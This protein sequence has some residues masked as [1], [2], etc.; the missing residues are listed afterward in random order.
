MALV[1]PLLVMILLGTATSAIA[2]SQNSSITNATR[3]ASRFGA[4]KTVDGNLSTWL[5]ELA[6]VA[7]RASIG[8]VNVTKSGH[9]ICVAFVHPAGTTIEDTTRSLT[10]NSLGPLEAFTP[11]YADLRPNTER[12][13][14]VVIRRPAT[15]ETGFWSYTASLEA[16]S[17]SMFERASL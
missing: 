3:E 2:Y 12:R 15:I 16:D 11:C 17:A 8:D 10:L 7:E 13:V 14:Q 4:T 5:S 6:L 9:E 1:F